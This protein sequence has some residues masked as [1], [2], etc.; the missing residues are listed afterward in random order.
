MIVGIGVDVV[1]LARFERSL[2][3]TPRLRDRLFAES[4]RSLPVASLAGRFAAKEALIKALGDS[5]GARW[6]DMVVERDEHGNPSFAL[7]GP[8]RAAAEARGITRV[9]LSMTHDAG[10]ACAFVVAES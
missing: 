3:R 9:H 2:T 4:E 8:A 1:D 7:H 5:V 6:H 10:V